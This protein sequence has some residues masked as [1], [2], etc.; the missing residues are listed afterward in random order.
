[1][2]LLVLA[3]TPPPLH[4]QSL[5]VRTLVRGLPAHG[6]Q[7][8]HVNLPLSR[9]AADIGRMRPG[10]L[11]ALARAIR[12]TR[13]RCRDTSFDAL[14]YVPAPGKRSAVV[15]DWLLLGAVRRLFPRLVLHWHAAG[16][17]DWLQTNASP[18]ERH[19]A[20]RALRAADLS[21]VLSPALRADAEAVAS[22]RIA[23]VPNGI[24]DPC[25]A[26]PPARPPPDP[27]LRI[28]FIGLCSEAKGVFGALAAVQ[29][30]NALA[31]PG[32]GPAFVLDLVGEAPD[33]AE[34]ARLRA[35]ASGDSAALRWHGPLTGAA[36]DACFARS[37]AFLFPTRYPHEGQPLVLLEAM[38]WD[39]PV[40]STRWR[41][42]PDTLPPSAAS[43][44]VAPGDVDGL[45]QALLRL[46]QAPP[47]AGFMRQ[48]YLN[49]YTEE[50]HLSSLATALRELS[51]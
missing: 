41:A 47:P 18:L 13:S 23:V 29:R 50:E 8:C 30:A 35:A 46:R 24:A 14:Y 21:L 40:V 42:I 9:T 11:L 49:F 19:L 36:K 16:L 1:M 2:N 45:A 39:L 26:G 17:A 25:P 22:R 51:A 31:G 6:H 28:L 43:A 7:V 20:V 15:R 5:M 44:L 38:A 27:S 37:H 3:Q 4:G 32:A 48:H 33:K 12:E 34:A 10:K